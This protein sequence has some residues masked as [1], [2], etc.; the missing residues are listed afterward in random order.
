MDLKEQSNSRPSSSPGPG[1][2]SDDIQQFTPSSAAKQ[3]DL[4]QESSGPLIPAS[5]SPSKSSP[6][7]QSKR[8]PGRFPR[9]DVLDDD[10]EE[11][12]LDGVITAA[13]KRKSL[14]ARKQAALE[15]QRQV[16]R[17]A[18]ENDEDSLDV[19]LPPTR[20]KTVGADRQVPDAL[21]IF[22]RTTSVAAPSKRQQH[23]AKLSGK[24]RTRKPLTETH[25]EY[26]AQEFGHADL[27]RRN[28]GSRPA[29]Q[30]QGRDEPVQ[31]TQVNDNLLRRHQR[32]ANELAKQKAAKY[33]GARRLPPK[34]P[35]AAVQLHSASGSPADFDSDSDDEYVDQQSV[36][37]SGDP[38]GDLDSADEAGDTTVVGD[39]GGGSP[40]PLSQEGLP[41]PVPDA[42]SN[43]EEDEGDDAATPKLRKPRSR[44]LRRV[45]FKSEDEADDIGRAPES[46]H[47]ETSFTGGASASPDLAGF[48]S[49]G[50]GFSQL[51]GET[52]QQQSSLQVSEVCRRC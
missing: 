6:T 47:I 9:F 19:V 40:N 48:G 42:M 7:L 12:T 13:A 52:Q 21:A 32:Q 26:A 24:Q 37:S 30:K 3:H 29:G 27:K 22:N 15:K 1:H 50:G 5:S 33:G 20:P 8:A 43:V 35:L 23:F 2:E 4:Q 45:E 36:A 38:D 31:Q 49:A 16:S 11:I 51:F 14:N 34:E 18:N 41:V 44:A 28:A 25:A 10:E 46:A 17:Q 39:G